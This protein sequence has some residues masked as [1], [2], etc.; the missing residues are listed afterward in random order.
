MILLDTS[1][2]INLLSGTNSHIN[3]IYSVIQNNSI[4]CGITGY[5]YMEVL[6]GIKSDSQVAQVKGYLDSLE[7]YE[8]PSTPETFDK[9]AHLY[10]TCRK[11]GLTIRSS[12]D[13]LIALT[14]IEHNLFLCHQ[15]KDFADIASVIPELKLFENFQKPY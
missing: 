8:L 6:Q 15:D 2:L 11:K 1:F 10:R 13:I 12:I 5:I 14:A 9:A 7:Y 4:E 3:S